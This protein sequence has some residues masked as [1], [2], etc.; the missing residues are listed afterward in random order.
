MLKELL[1]EPP[2]RTTKALFRLGGYAVRCVRE[3][4]LAS[5]A[6]IR[7]QRETADDAVTQRNIDI[8]TVLGEL[9]LESS[10]RE[11]TVD[12]AQV[13]ELL[14]N[15]SSE[16]PRVAFEDALNP[17]QAIAVRHLLMKH[18]ESQ[19]SDADATVQ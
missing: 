8:H 19:T 9:M 10:G 5:S 3:N 14:A 4:P 7:R 11:S 18:H 6:I 13:T 17:H 2:L 12:T 15:I 16:R 1:I